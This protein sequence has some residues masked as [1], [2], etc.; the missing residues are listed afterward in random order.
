MTPK[1]KMLR[2]IVCLCMVLALCLSFAACRNTGNDQTTEA[3]NAPDVTYTLQIQSEGGVAMPDLEIYIYEND[4]LQDLVAVTA[5]DAEGKAT[6]TVKKS[7]TYAAVLVNTPSGYAVESSYPITGA[8]T[9]IVLKMEL[10]DGDLSTAVYALGDVM[11]DFSF[12]DHNGNSYKLSELL[13]TKKAVVLNFFRLDG[14][15]SQM[16]LPCLQ[17]AYEKYADSVAVLCMDPVDGDNDAIAEFA[18]SLELTLPMGACEAEWVNA[19]QIFS[20]PTTVVIDRFGTVALNHGQAVTKTYE[21]TD[22]FAYFTGVD[23]T[24]NAVEDM[25]ELVVSKPAEGEVENPTEIFGGKMEFDLTLDP[26]KVHYVRIPNVDNVWMQVASGEVNVEY[27]GKTFQPSGGSVGLFVSAPSTF[28]PAVVGFRNVGSERITFHVTMANLPGTY[29][30]PYSLKVGEFSTSVSGGNEQGVYFKYWATED[31]YFTLQCLS[32]SPNVE[33]A[34][35]IMN[36]ANSTMYTLES[37]GTENEQGQRVVNAPVKKGQA[38][39]ITIDTVPDDTNKYPA[40]NFQ[41]LASFNAGEIK[42][43]EKVESVP[44][45]VTVTDENRKPLAGV[46]VGFIPENPTDLNKGANWETDENGVAS[47]YLPKDNYTVSAVVPNGYKATTTQAKLTPEE[48]YASLKFDTYVVVMCDY[49]V[50]VTDEQGNALSGA[51]VVIGSASGYTNDRGVFTANLEKGD[52]TAVVQKNGYEIAEQ[53][54]A[55]GSTVLNVKLKTSTGE[56]QNGVDYT[57]TVTDYTGTPMTGITVSLYRYGMLSGMAAV[58]D[59]GVATFRLRADNYTVGL[60]STQGVKLKY[61]EVSLTAKAP[62][63]TVQVAVNGN[64]GNRETEFWGSYYEIGTGS[65]WADLTDNTNATANMSWEALTDFQGW[66]YVFVPKQAGV[67]RFTVSDGALLA[68][69]GSTNFPNL[70]M[71]TSVA[72]KYFEIEVRQANVDEENGYV[73]AV[74]STS[75]ADSAVIS[76]QRMGDVPA[77]LPTVYYSNKVTPTAFKL[78]QSGTLHYVDVTADSTVE[79]RDDGFYYLNGKKLYMNIGKS[80]PYITVAE[81]VGLSYNETTGGW[82]QSSMATGLKGYQIENGETVAVEQYN[83]A[84]KEYIQNCDPSNGLYPVTD[85]LAHMLQKTG[86][87]RGW[88]EQDDPDYLFGSKSVNTDIAWL[89]A[90]CYVD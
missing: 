85:D 30:N 87:Y 14:V 59:N 5:T 7:D 21:F 67:Y 10:V 19:M 69:F 29:E 31:G 42:E 53:A 18:K 50:S 65:T 28:E 15:N 2:H 74:K 40:A 20:Y 41:M 81:M 73:V 61:A 4:T 45:A 66:V 71:D 56:V 13:Q 84:I 57:V 8:N 27:G 47:G 86:E 23:Y 70:S 12:T 55:A 1:R 39:L 9:R 37:D 49:S 34:F 58:D 78:N 16:E 51:L 63:T 82:D 54:F 6:F 90:C 11:Q 36:L 62:S 24:Q 89:F 3:P 26:G 64:T 88:W 17:E 22:I 79:R 44:F 76:I 68:Y 32:I 33:Y 35:S 80:A 72:E 77:E 43:T 60:T 52:Y 48:P 75:G 38:L 46:N 83:G 25:E